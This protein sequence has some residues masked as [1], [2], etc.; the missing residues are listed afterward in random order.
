MMYPIARL[1]DGRTG[2]IL[3]QRNR[4]QAI[5]LLAGVLKEPLKNIVKEAVEEF[6][7]EQESDDA[8]GETSSYQF[9]SLAV[10][11]F[12]AAIYLANKR[13]RNA[14][15]VSEGSRRHGKDSAA[16]SV[17]SREQIAASD[18]TNTESSESESDDHDDEG[19][20]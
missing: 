2:G 11:G 10:F 5:Q 12:V 14:S 7:S 13:D 6:E 18:A 9:V 16:E 17:E 15:S 8:V 19:P 20:K 1:A 4:N 3:S